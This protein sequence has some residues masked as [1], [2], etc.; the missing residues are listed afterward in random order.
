LVSF[1]YLGTVSVV[2]VFTTQLENI[3]TNGTSLCEP[4]LTFLSKDN[5]FA[6]STPLLLCDG[7]LLGRIVIPN[8]NFMYQLSG[9]DKFGDPFAYTKR[10]SVK[11][12]RKPYILQNILDGSVN[13]TISIGS[14]AYIYFGLKSTF[15]ATSQLN[16]LINVKTSPAKLKLKYQS[17]VTVKP[18]DIEIS[19]ITIE[20][21]DTDML[22]NYVVKITAKAKS[23]KLTLTNSQ[24]ITLVMVSCT[25]HLS[26]YSMFP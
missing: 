13:K 12:P 7:Y 15:A 16:F 10:A 11:P 4:K 25:I 26:Y 17:I 22:G 1:L 5:E 9:C 24:H 6:G 14:K 19:V 18:D 23:E 2:S 8:V 20:T 3:Q 21:K